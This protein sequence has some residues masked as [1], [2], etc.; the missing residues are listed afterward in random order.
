[1][2]KTLRIIKERY[3]LGTFQPTYNKRELVNNEFV[4]QTNGLQ[5]QWFKQT[6]NPSFTIGGTCMH[7]NTHAYKAHTSV[8]FKY[9]S[10]LF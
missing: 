7:S 3:F 1:M 5:R 8:H 4:Q 10:S 6:L 9:P 2:A